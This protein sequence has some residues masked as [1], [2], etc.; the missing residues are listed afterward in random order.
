MTRDEFPCVRAQKERRETIR[1]IV[2]RRASR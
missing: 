1:G 2:R